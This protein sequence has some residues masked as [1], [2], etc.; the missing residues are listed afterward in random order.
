MVLSLWNE[1]L[2]V[3]KMAQ[4]IETDAA[5]PDD[6]SSTPWW[7]EKTDSHSLSY[8]LN[9]WPVACTCAHTQVHTN[10]EAILKEIDICVYLVLL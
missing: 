1:H 6:L 8:D 7:R 9:A 4:E 10:K 2:R 5:K 3:G